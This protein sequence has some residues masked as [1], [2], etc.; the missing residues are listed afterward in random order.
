MAQRRGNKEQI[1]TYLPASL[2]RS[3]TELADREG[4]SLSNYVE[5]LLIEHLGESLGAEK[6]AAL[7]ADSSLLASILEEQDYE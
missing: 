7:K 5:K 3:L 6:L 4:R 1:S 2:K